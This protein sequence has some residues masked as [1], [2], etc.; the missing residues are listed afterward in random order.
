MR[1]D[2]LVLSC[3][4]SRAR[5]CA[6]LGLALS[7]C[8]S[9]SRTDGEQVKQL[10]R[11]LDQAARTNDCAEEKL[12]AALHQIAALQEIIGCM[13]SELAHRPQQKPAERRFACE[14]NLFPMPVPPLLGRITHVQ[15]RL[16]TIRITENLT[17]AEIKPG[18]QFAVFDDH[19][20]KA[21][22][23]VTEADPDKGVAY[24]G[25]DGR[26]EEI[27]IGDSASTRGVN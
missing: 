23:R 10:Q 21:V 2:R 11:A 14:P 17:N 20:F 6:I 5:T 8:V 18:F 13:E 27:R 25:L 15:G 4:R 24:C 22:A 9:S 19:G 3:C 16:C 1:V 26:V 7:G 12:R